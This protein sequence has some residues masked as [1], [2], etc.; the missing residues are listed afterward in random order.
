MGRWSV[1]RVG[2]GSVPLHQSL[3]PIR[4]APL[5]CKPPESAPLKCWSAASSPTAGCKTW[6]LWQKPSVTALNKHFTFKRS[7]VFYT[8]FVYK[9]NWHKHHATENH[10]SGFDYSCYTTWTINQ[11]HCKDL[12]GEMLAPDML[13]H[14]N[15]A[16][17]NNERF[18]HIKHSQRLWT[19]EELTKT[20]PV[21]VYG[22]TEP[23]IISHFSML[24]ICWLWK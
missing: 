20:L 6:S 14:V 17:Q 7:T 5:S 15:I 3:Q 2:W 21:L 13:V 23:L 18:I 9:W 24:F 19:F 12:L 11:R 10:H 4:H 22:L 1:H 8:I 16:K